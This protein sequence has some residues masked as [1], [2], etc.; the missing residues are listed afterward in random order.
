VGEST[1]SWAARLAGPSEEEEREAVRVAIFVF[2][3]PKCKT[4]LVFVYFNGIFV[5]LQK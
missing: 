4:V 3:F 1:R 2:L 5:E